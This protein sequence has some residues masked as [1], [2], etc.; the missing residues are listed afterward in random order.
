MPRSRTVRSSTTT[1]SRNSPRR[2]RSGWTSFIKGPQAEDRMLSYDRI[3]LAQVTRVTAKATV[4]AIVLGCQ[5]ACFGHVAFAAD[6]RSKDAAVRV[7]SARDDDA[8]KTASQDASPAKTKHRQIPTT[9]LEIAE[10]LGLPLL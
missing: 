8:G 5:A 10:A 3:H 1:R 7:Q 4:L 9:P 2:R 6:A